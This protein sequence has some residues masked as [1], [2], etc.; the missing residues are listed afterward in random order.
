MVFG[1]GDFEGE[2]GWWVGVARSVDGG[3]AVEEVNV[4]SGVGEGESKVLV[5]GVAR[6]TISYAD[7]VF[8]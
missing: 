2:E 1:R 4:A 5:A 8:R 3:D 7:H 6:G